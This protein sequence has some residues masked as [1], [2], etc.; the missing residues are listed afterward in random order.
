MIE[1]SS[2]GIDSPY[3]IN[4]QNFARSVPSSNPHVV[5]K[6]SMESMDL[7]ALDGYYLCPECQNQYR[8]TNNIGNCKVCQKS[9]NK[10]VNLKWHCNICNCEVTG[11][12]K[13][14]HK[15]SYKHQQ[16]TSLRCN[17]Q[18]ILTPVPTQNLSQGNLQHGGPSN[19]MGTYCNG[20]K[21]PELPFS[22]NPSSE[23]TSSI[24]SSPDTFIQ[25]APF[26]SDPNL[27][28]GV[29]QQPLDANVYINPS[30][31]SGISSTEF[32]GSA[33]S[34]GVSF[35]SPSG[36]SETHCSTSQSGVEYPSDEFWI[37]LNKLIGQINQISI[38]A[39]YFE[40]NF[41][42]VYTQYPSDSS[43]EIYQ[44]GSNGL[45]ESIIRAG[46]AAPGR[47]L[48]KAK[49][50]IPKEITIKPEKVE[51]ENKKEK[52]KEKDRGCFSSLFLC[53]KVK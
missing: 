51:N 53:F 34:D 44:V 26:N 10:K 4:G 24:P 37:N 13:S 27:L 30:A 47:K 52:E 36:I 45:K 42:Q 49:A 5:R 14:A 20:N 32:N 12:G 2:D 39:K 31:Y 9:K 16:I 50:P 33:F 17:A 41:Q 7:S 43:M 8:K 35:F 19:L 25:S 15:Q 38:L 6:G 46:A 48:T 28:G 22:S 21:S 18:N 1:P 23:P 3:M 11:N 29:Q 40:P